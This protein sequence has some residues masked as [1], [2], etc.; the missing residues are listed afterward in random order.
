MASHPR[1]VEVED[2]EQF[3]GPEPIDRLMKKARR[4]FDFRVAKVNSTTNAG[5]VAELLSSSTPLMNSLGIITEWR[6]I[7]GD[8]DFFSITKNI[9][10]GLQG[11]HIQLSDSNKRTYE[12]VVYENSVKN[13]LDH[14]FVIVHDPQ[15]LPMINYNKKTLPLDL[16][17]PPRPF[18]PEQGTLELPDS[19]Y[20]KL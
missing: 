4:L 10:N 2:Y 5:G 20:R 7:S 8:L 18:E 14:D 15:P 1:G 17:M 16:A 9:H 13:H 6:A 19:A 12:E 3:V 11:K